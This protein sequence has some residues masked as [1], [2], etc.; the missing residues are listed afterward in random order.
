MKTYSL[1][2]GLLFSFGCSAFTTMPPKEVS[3]EVPHPNEMQPSVNQ[4][5]VQY[6]YFTERDFDAQVNSLNKEYERLASMLA[7][8]KWY[9]NNDIDQIARM[10]DETMAHI[11]LDKTP[12]G[13]DI[14][15]FTK[16]QELARRCFLLVEELF[17]VERQFRL[18]HGL[19]GD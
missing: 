7:Y 6:S 8:S 4:R 13:I 1:L 10:I 14:E 12:S 3:L 18:Q 9:V 11:Q 17:K 5:I 2:A 16:D 15:S 19:G